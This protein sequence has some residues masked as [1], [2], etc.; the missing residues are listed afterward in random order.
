MLTWLPA[1]ESCRTIR[2]NR[3][4]LCFSLV[5]LSACQGRPSSCLLSGNSVQPIAGC[6]WKAQ[7]DQ[8][9]RLVLTHIHWGWEV[10]DCMAM[11]GG[12]GRSHQ[13][14]NPQS[15]RVEER[16]RNWVVN[17]WVSVREALNT[18]LQ[19]PIGGAFLYLTEHMLPLAR[20]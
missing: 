19:S 17:E 20:A 8:L 2:S 7:R 15:D 11:E 16:D 10:G 5:F 6:V 4:S 13:A 9:P 12:I 1:E 3:V 18:C 14:P